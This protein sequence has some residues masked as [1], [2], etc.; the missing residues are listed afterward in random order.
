M[1]TPLTAG[2]RLSL[3]NPAMPPASP[4]A[5]PPL[6]WPDC[7]DIRVTLGPQTDRFTSRGLDTFLGQT[8]RVHPNSDRQGYRTDG[9]AIEF[10]GRPDI[11]SDP[12]PL[13]AV[14]VP[15]DGKPI[16]LLR[17]GQSTGG[18][19]KIA[20]VIGADLDWFGQMVPGDS[21]RFRAVS[22]DQALVAAREREEYFQALARLLNLP[23]DS[24]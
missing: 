18:Y 4:C 6:R 15:G 20:T 13:G 21:L 12:T 2:Q 22:R 16:V 1:G 3:R 17:D 23:A 10:A 8:Y 11:I 24:D 19:A 5:A 7:F 9:P 14:Q